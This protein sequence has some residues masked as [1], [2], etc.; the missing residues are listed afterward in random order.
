MTDETPQDEVL[1]TILTQGDLAHETDG[2]LPLAEFKPWHLPRKHLVRK[3]QWAAVVGRLLDDLPD[4][5]MIKY[6]CLPGED[7]IDVQVLAEVCQNKGRV[8]RYLGFDETLPTVSRST[9]RV[10]AEQIVR[11]MS[12]VDPASE[13]VPDAFSS[14]ARVDSR[15]NQYLRDGGSHDVVNLDMCDAFTSDAQKPTHDA[16]VE[17]ITHQCNRRGE[18]WLLF[19]TTRSEPER[20]ASNELAAYMDRIKANASASKTFQADVA[21][22]AGCENI[23]E[24]DAFCV[25]LSGRISN[26]PHLS[27][28]L[29]AL[30][31]GKW[32]LGIVAQGDPWRVDLMS[33]WCYRTG[34]LSGSGQQFA[35]EP[36]NLFSLAFRFEKIKTARLD[37]AGLAVEHAPGSGA[38]ERY[39]A[40]NESALAEKMVR[41]ILN[42]TRDIDCDVQ[43]QA[44]LHELLMEESAALLRVRYYS[45]TAYRLWAGSVPKVSC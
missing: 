25:E 33:V 22:L 2:E 3:E 18:P 31:I 45:E 30:G 14:I 6:L 43:G 5:R 11:Q 27:G 32:L 34:L 9:Q 19:V 4:R 7:L 37:P 17:L 10:S 12:G 8:L 13:V 23:D 40:F 16:M 42:N 29:L 36:P 24:V 44:G 20:I 39:A 1:D 28:R 26:D 41:G 21:A 38:E 15:G 35:S